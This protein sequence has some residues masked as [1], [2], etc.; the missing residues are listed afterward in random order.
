MFDGRR[1]QAEIGAGGIC[2]DCIRSGLVSY[3]CSQACW[4]ANMVSRV[5]TLH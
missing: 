1:I 5:N 2:Q 4:N 3:F